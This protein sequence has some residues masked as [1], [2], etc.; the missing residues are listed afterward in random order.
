[1]ETYVRFHHLNTYLVFDAN[2]HSAFDVLHNLFQGLYMGYCKV[3]EILGQII[4]NKIIIMF[5][6]NYGM[7]QIVNTTLA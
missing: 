7:H 5:N 1:M 2:G 3:G 4:N 6:V